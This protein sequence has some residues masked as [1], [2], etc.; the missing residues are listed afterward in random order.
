MSKENQPTWGGA[1][2]GSGRPELP[3]A[4]K[5]CNITIKLLPRTYKQLGKL[6]KQ[7]KRSRGRVVEWFIEAPQAEKCRKA[8]IRSK[9]P[10]NGD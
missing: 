9:P 4:E 6:A 5:R 7:S 2:P 10:I 1:R 8:L 3:Q